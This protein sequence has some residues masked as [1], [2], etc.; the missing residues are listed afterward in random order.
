[1][2]ITTTMFGKTLRVYATPYNMKEDEEYDEVLYVERQ[3][4]LY[5]LMSP[6]LKDKKVAIVYRVDWLQAVEKEERYNDPNCN[7]F[8]VDG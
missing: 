2:M 7:R 1:M 4:T 6:S 5:G 3:E 8:T